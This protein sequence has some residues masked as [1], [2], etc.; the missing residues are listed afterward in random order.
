MRIIVRTAGSSE[1][2]LGHLMRCIAL[3]Q[4]GRTDGVQTS[5][6]VDDD[7]VARAVL[8]KYGLDCTVVTDSEDPSWLELVGG[9]DVVVYDGYQFG[10]PEHICASATGA[11][12]VAIDDFGE[13]PFPVDVLVNTNPL[14]ETGYTV[15]PGTRL[16]LGPDYALVRE[17][18]HQREERVRDS[19]GV[20][21]VTLGGADAEAITAKVLEAVAGDDTFHRTLIVQGPAS[22]SAVRAGPRLEVVSDPPD[23]AAVFDAADAAI[24]AAGVTT[25][26]LLCL[27]VPTALIRTA[28]NQRQV[29]RV[30]TDLGAALYAGTAAEID[31][32]LAPTLATLGDRAVRRDLAVRGRRLI[33]G[34]GAERVLVAVKEA[35]SQRRG[36]S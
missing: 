24:A 13:G 32:R 7:P 17:E 23:V 30:A 5:F 26:E 21:L 31:Q 9:D 12:V 35:L 33:D 28:D 8:N 14:P 20:L 6:V 25:W 4:A 34:R 15:L 3:A 16:L 11:L 1:I 22:N 18:F 27:G 29:V 10:P 36:P 19:D 2:G